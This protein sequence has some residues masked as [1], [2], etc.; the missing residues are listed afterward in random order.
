MVSKLVIF[1][2][3]WTTIPVYFAILKKKKY[4]YGN[5]NGNK[6]KSMAIVTGTVMK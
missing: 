2:G 3:H 4:E 6:K 1:V 5:I